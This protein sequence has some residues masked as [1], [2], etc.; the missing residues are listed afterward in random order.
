MGRATWISNSVF[1]VPAGSALIAQINDR[2]RCLPAIPAD[3][4]VAGWRN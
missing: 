3:S 2:S 1:L 4:V